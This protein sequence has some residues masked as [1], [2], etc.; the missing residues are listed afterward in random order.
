MLNCRPQEV[1]SASGGFVRQVPP[2]PVPPAVR[3]QENNIVRKKNLCIEVLFSGEQ[4]NE[5]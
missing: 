2:L 5:F 3:A 1:D 4:L